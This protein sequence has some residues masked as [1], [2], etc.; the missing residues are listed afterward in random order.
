MGVLTYRTENVSIAAAPGT[1]FTHGLGVAPALGAGEVFIRHRT[2]TFIAT[3]L[4]SSSQIIV[5]CPS[6]VPVNVDL[7]V[8]IFHS[9]MI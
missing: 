1:T 5:L 8:M 2:A 7:T 6:V 9:I 4:T 3:M